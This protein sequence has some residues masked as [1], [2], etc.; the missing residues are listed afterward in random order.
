MA[1]NSQNLGREMDTQIYAAQRIQNWLNVKKTTPRHI[2]I[3]LSKINSE[4]EFSKQQET[5]EKLHI[6][7]PPP[8]MTIGVNLK[9]NFSGQ[10][11]ME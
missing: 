8:H 10:E 2:K 6:R 1:K 11:R 3:K 4:K 5:R 7:E 9:R